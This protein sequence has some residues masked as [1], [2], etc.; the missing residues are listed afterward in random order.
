MS[1]FL[2]ETVQVVNNILDERNLCYGPTYGLK[3]DK[4]QSQKQQKIIILQQLCCRFG[5]VCL[6][7]LNNQWLLKSVG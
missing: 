6:E 3:Q 2:S 5:F 7:M 4:A 1:R